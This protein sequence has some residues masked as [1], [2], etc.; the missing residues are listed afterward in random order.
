M[1]APVP[2]KQFAGQPSVLKAIALDWSRDF[3]VERVASKFGTRPTVVRK[4]LA[5]DEIQNYL[6]GRLLPMEQTVEAVRHRLFEEVTKDAFSAQPSKER[7]E[8]RRMLANNLIP[9]MKKVVTEHRFVVEAPAKISTVEEWQRLHAPQPPIL[10]AEV[11]EDVEQQG[12]KRQA[13]QE[14]P[15]APPSGAE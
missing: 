7:A 8:A 12:G 5:R 2:Y 10:E 9:E 15:E 11:I 1:S 4:I 3:N 6:S 14:P 13:P